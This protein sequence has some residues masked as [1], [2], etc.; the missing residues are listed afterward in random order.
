[1]QMHHLA[2][3]GSFLGRI[4]SVYEILST[5]WVPVWIVQSLKFQ[6]FAGENPGLSQISIVCRLN[7]QRFAAEIH[8]NLDGSLVQFLLIKIPMEIPS[9]IHWA[10]WISMFDA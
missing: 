5:G 6:R 3:F 10:C 9:F 1:M 7:L 2:H 4:S 8:T